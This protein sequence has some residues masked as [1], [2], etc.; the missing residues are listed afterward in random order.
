M[1]PLVILLAATLLAGCGARAYV[2]V[3]AGRVTC[4]GTTPLPT[5]NVLLRCTNG[6]EELVPWGELWP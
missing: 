2:V 5:Q 6:V 1:R 4:R 3:K